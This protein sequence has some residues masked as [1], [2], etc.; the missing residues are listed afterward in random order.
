M[1]FTNLF[2]LIAAC[3]VTTVH[4]AGN[5]GASCDKIGTLVTGTDLVAY[6]K[7]RDGSSAYSQ[8]DMNK[9]IANYG[10][11]LACA[12]N[13]NF[14]KSCSN[15]QVVSGTTFRCTCK[16]GSTTTTINL[17]NCI[18]NQDGVLACA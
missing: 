11:S 1:H 10:G 17:N 3:V 4:A 13:G 5:F 6:C 18:A 12:S 2:A 16:P 7:K 14:G 8:L 15:C 9:C